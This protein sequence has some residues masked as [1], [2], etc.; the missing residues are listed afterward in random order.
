MLNQPRV[1][2]FHLLNDRSGSP[3]ILRQ[4]LRGWQQE[5]REVH[6]YTSMHNDGFLSHIEGIIYHNGWYRFKSNP[7]L[8]LVY[9][10]L[11]QVILFGKMYA[12]VSANDI[13]Y[14]NTVLP[15]AAALLGKTKGCRV[16]YHI[17]ESTVNPRLLRWFLLK[18]VSSTAS[19]IINVSEFVAKSNGIG[20]IRNHIVYNAIDAEFMTGI[21]PKSPQIL[22]RNVLMLCSLKAYKGVFEYIRL[23]K[24]HQAYSFQMVLN[25][26]QNEID[27][28]FR[29]TDFPD[30]LRLFPTQQY[31]H[32]FYQWAD[33][34]VNLSLPH[35]W[36]ETFGLTII[37]GMA[38][39]LPAIVPPVGGILEVVEPGA[40]GLAVDAGDR[41]ALNAA[42]KELMEDAEQY[43][44]FSEA[45]KGRLALFQEEKMLSEIN[46]I[47]FNSSKI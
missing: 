22:P 43:R 10:L 31:L 28:F 27:D 18:V 26:N 21:L 4:V 13:V 32:G 3:K 39:G 36:V 1:F 15:F 34:V 17:H 47:L 45:S 38:Y 19:E 35:Q 9:F 8:R 29:G 11:S 25:A 42:L 2:A 20:Q 5:G 44:R 37:E 24:D 46:M 23:A 40:T 16:I 41:V 33:V 7:W 12:K 30:N 6:L 14:V